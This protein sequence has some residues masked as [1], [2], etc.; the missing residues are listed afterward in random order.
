MLPV[1]RV[2]LHIREPDYLYKRF[3]TIPQCDWADDRADGLSVFT[4]KRLTTGRLREGYGKATG[5]HAGCTE[6]DTTKNVA[7]LH[8]PQYS[9]NSLSAQE[10]WMISFNIKSD[11]IFNFSVF[12]GI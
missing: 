7:L 10:I 6:N 2:L 4:Y 5:R 3:G 8:T 12:E 11:P 9:K 1:A